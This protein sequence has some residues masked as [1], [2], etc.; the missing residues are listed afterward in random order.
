MDLLLFLVFAL[1]LYRLS[2]TGRTFSDEFM[3]RNTT[4]S[5]NGIFVMLIFLSH[6]S[7]YCPEDFSGRI[8]PG[9]QNYLGQFV[10]VSFLFFSGYGIALS[11][12]KKGN[13][14]I[15]AFPKNRLLRLWCHFLLTVPLYI[16]ASR[17]LGI[18]YSGLTIACALFAWRSVGNTDWY[19]FATLCLYIATWIGCTISLRLTGGGEHGNARGVLVGTILVSFAV[20][21]YIFVVRRF[22]G[23][24]YY[25]TVFM[26]PAGMLFALLKE[27]F[28]KWISKSN[29]HC[30]AAFCTSV[31]LLFLGRE[32]KNDNLLF[33]DSQ[34]LLFMTAILILTMKLRFRSPLLSLLGGYAFEIYML[35]RIPMM[36]LQGHIGN[37]YLCFILCMGCTAVLAYGIRKLENRL[38][39]LLFPTVPSKV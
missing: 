25:D 11:V 12:L 32:C 29:L 37:P 30:T 5:V 16:A 38:D 2:F 20:T 31:L 13:A 27:P 15:H 22:R 39:G 19:I 3:D 21:V 24:A 34:A 4:V 10:V 9:F 8:Y 26:Y 35:H 14:Y 28:R 6:F 23:A 33:F 17:S 36:L 18:R 1:S 7:T